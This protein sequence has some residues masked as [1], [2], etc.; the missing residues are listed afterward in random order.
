MWCSVKDP[1]TGNL[2]LKEFNGV[3]PQNNYV[4]P[5]SQCAHLFVGLSLDLLLARINTYMYDDND[6]DNEQLN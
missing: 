5:Y 4:L 3:Q 2:K 1:R 6:N